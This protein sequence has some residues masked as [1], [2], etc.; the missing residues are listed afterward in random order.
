[1]QFQVMGQSGY[2]QH[3]LVA[4]DRVLSGP[5]YVQRATIL[6]K[7]DSEHLLVLWETVDWPSRG[8]IIPTGFA[9]GYSGEGS[10]G[11]SLALCMLSEHRVPIYHVRM[12][13]TVFDQIDGGYFPDLWQ[14]GISQRALQCEMPIPNWTFVRHWELTQQRRLWRVQSWRWRNTVI[15]WNES[16]NIVDDFNWEVGDILNRAIRAL[17][18]SSPPEDRQQVGLILRDA[19]IKFSR[20]IRKSLDD[21]DESIGKNDVKGVL[22]AMDLPQ[23]IIQK[24]RKAYNLTNALQ[25]DTGAGHDM[26]KACFNRSTEAMAEIIS[27]RFPRVHDLRNESLIRPN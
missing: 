4:L 24:G 5:I 1:M 6:T 25:H 22:E 21:D 27:V 18:R 26:A 15:E 17:T 2:T 3:C 7:N 20:I 10:R 11:F 23:E 12:R 8:I 9:S 14:L 13:E 16:A 19:W